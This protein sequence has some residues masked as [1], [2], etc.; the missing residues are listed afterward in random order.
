M[1]PR[2]GCPCKSTIPVCRDT[3]AR[4]L[5]SSSNKFQVNELHRKSE[6]RKAEKHMTGEGQNTICRKWQ[7]RVFLF[8][9]PCA[10]REETGNPGRVRRC[11]LF[12]PSNP[13]TVYTSEK[14]TALTGQRCF[15][16]SGTGEGEEFSYEKSDYPGKSRGSL[17]T[18]IR[19]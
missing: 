5:G 7:N 9:A 11:V 15:E 18:E 12:F 1:P 14:R 6:L 4:K 10:E 3:L 16:M 8:L 19:R 17:R 2:R 13:D